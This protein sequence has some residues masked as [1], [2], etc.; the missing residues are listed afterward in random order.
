MTAKEIKQQFPEAYNDIIA[1]ER[2]RVESWLLYRKTSP[3]AVWVGI[4]SG[5]QIS[6]AE[7]QAL[8]KGTAKGY[9]NQTVLAEARQLMGINKK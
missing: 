5:K 4:A 2:D 1:E 8:I 9:V 7:M 6:P 3:E